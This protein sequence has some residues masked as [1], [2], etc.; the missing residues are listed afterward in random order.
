MATYLELFALRSNSD[1]IDKITVAVV[2]K[3]QSLLDGGAPTAAEVAWAN[4]AIQSPVEKAKTLTNYVLAA[5]SGLTTG[6]ITSATD[7][8]IQTNV[9]SAVD[10]LIAGGA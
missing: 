6:Q 3:A 8:A 4:D 10:A 2:K 5:N 7:A 9:D 1:L